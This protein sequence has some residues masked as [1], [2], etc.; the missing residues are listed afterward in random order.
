VLAVLV[1][2][3]RHVFALKWTTVRLIHSRWLQ[4]KSAR[5]RF[6]FPHIFQVSNW[7]NWRRRQTLRL[8]CSS[9]TTCTQRALG[10]FHSGASDPNRYIPRS[11]QIQIQIHPCPVKSQQIKR[12]CLKSSLH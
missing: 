10:H 9:C 8:L 2:N 7:T 12:T 3:Y 6:L 5:K 11:I 1:K 4:I